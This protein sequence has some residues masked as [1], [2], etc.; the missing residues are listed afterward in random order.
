MWY[1]YLSHE[2]PKATSVIYLYHTSVYEIICLYPDH[3]GYMTKVIQHFFF[4]KKLFFEKYYYPGWGTR[5]QVNTTIYSPVNKYLIIWY[6]LHGRGIK[7]FIIRVAECHECDKYLYH[8]RV[9]ELILHYT[10]PM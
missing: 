4:Q 5:A 7:V 9:Y 1:R 6:L 10:P 2:W 3:P 8:T